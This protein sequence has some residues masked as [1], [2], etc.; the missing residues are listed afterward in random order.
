M[1]LIEVVELVG[2]IGA[3]PAHLVITFWVLG[4]LNARGITTAEK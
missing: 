3:M 4:K 1:T 2:L